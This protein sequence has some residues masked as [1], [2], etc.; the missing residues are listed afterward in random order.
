MVEMK[1]KGIA[2]DATKYN[3]PVVI[4]TDM[5]EKH[6]LPI[7]I[8]L[9]EAN[10]IITAMENISVPRPLTHDLM[11]T[12]LDTLG[13]T[14][15]SIVVTKFSEGTFY[16]EITLEAKEAKYVIDA[17][18]SDAVALALRTKSPIYV[19][20]NVVLEAT[21]LD[22]MKISKETEELKKWLENLKPSDFGNSPMQ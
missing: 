8:G 7:W 19:S 6:M 16:A 20:E 21:I 10:A 17:R 12:M 11:K 13:A 2:I 9:F 1:V 4:L 15:T 14:M 22:E 18:P 3:T 5:E